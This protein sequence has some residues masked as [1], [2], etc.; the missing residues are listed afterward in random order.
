MTTTID[1]EQTQHTLSIYVTNK[2][3]VLARVAQTFSRRGFNI[4]SLV[5]SPAI[6]GTFSRMTIG[7]SGDPL[8]LDQIIAQL[9]KLIDVLHC[10]DHS[11]EQAVI[12]ELALVKI[13]CETSRR[14]EALQVVE[15]FGCKTVDLTP[16]SMIVMATGPTDKVDACINMISN[17]EIVE[18]VRTGKVLMA[19]GDEVT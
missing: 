17:F 1:N 8:G 2:P 5:V 12:R 14:S 19:R 7:I 11:G 3:G 13:K 16:T 10:I 18:L 15:H 9:N 6:D 4:E